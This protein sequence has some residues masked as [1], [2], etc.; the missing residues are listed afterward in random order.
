MAVI[1]PY[2]VRGVT[3]HT[4]RTLPLW[5]ELLEALYWYDC[6]TVSV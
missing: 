6:S 1:W 5:I 3:V 4:Y 2:Q